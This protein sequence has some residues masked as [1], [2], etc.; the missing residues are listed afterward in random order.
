[1]RL[2][3]L[4]R[5]P[6]KESWPTSSILGSTGRRLGVALAAIGVL[7]AGVLW[8]SLT[9]PREAL[10]EPAAS[11]SSPVAGKGQPPKPQPAPVPQQVGLRALALTGEAVGLKGSFDR[12]G[13]ELLTMVLATN[14]RGETAFYSTLR[15]S[16][17]E[18]GMFL[19]LADGKIVPIAV[20][21]DPVAD[22][23]G[24]LI[25]GFGEHP[26][27][28]MGDDGSVAFI[29]TLGGGRGAAAVLLANGGSLRTIA[30]T[31][32]KAPVIL[33]GIGVFAGFEA[34]S[35]DN[36]GDVAFLAL[37]QH[38]RETVEAVYVARRVGAV[39]R[40]EKIAASGEPAPGGGFYTGFGTPVVNNKGAIAFPAVVKLG[41]ALGGIFV[42]PTDGSAH[43]FL[44]TGDSA[45]TGGIFARFSERIGFDDSGRVVFGAFINGSGPDFGIFVADGAERRVVAARGQ[46]APG[47]GRYEA[48]GAWPA[49][50]HNGELAFV[51]ATDRGQGFDGVFRMDAAGK[52][53][54]VI[55]PG[56]ALMDGGKLNSLGLYPTVAIA[57]DGAVSLLGIV[58]RDGKEL[59]AVLRYGLAPIHRP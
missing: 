42:A 20:A 28:S 2:R 17:A 37:V 38:G 5:R 24:Q 7:W 13:L 15:R 35:I 19:A 27:P 52:V 54:R 46:A 9:P 3:S 12:F 43:L 44:G 50:S 47:G 56:D 49:I 10:P 14:N 36:R 51:A 40:L 16:Q 30:A 11:A 31:G 34:V 21:G 22:Q 55:A 4:S 23:A 29:A 45:P 39:H 26:G 32:M 58:A 41:P 1:M 48:F 25:A 8:V 59:Y 18:E 33:G 53:T 6:I 57:S